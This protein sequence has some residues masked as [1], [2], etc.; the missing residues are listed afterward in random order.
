MPITS[1]DSPFEVVAGFIYDEDT[2]TFDLILP[3]VNPADS[4]AAAFRRRPRPQ[5]DTITSGSSQP[6]TGSGCA[7]ASEWLAEHATDGGPFDS[8]HEDG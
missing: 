5:P 4:A 1:S 8:R 6:H 2:D 3:P 7:P